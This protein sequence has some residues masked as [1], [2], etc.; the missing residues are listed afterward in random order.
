MN[1][2]NKTIEQLSQRT[3]SNTGKLRTEDERAAFSNN[4]RADIASIL[5]QLNKVYYPLVKTLMSEQALNA[6]DYGLS[7][8]VI[9]T[10]ITANAASAKAYW[11][12]RLVRARTIKETIDVILAEIS[13][14]E[15]LVNILSKGS[16]FDDSEIWNELNE[17]DLNLKQLALDTMGPDYVFGGD[18]LSNLNYSLSQSIDALGAFFNGWP[19]TGNTYT[20]T[21]PSIALSILLSQITLDI[22]LPQNV[23]TNL[24]TDLTAIRNFTGMDN[25]TATPNYS[26]HGSIDYVTDG[27]SLEESIQ[28]LDQVI[29][30]L[31]LP[32]LDNKAV[33]FGDGTDTPATDPNYFVYDEGTSRLGLGTSTPEKTLDVR[34]IIQHDNGV[35]SRGGN[36]RGTAAIDL[37][38][39][40]SVATQ[41][42]S[43]TRAVVLGGQNNSSTAPDA[44]S[45]G[46]ACIAQGQTSVALGKDNLA[47][48]AQATAFGSNNTANGSVAFAKGY[49]NQANGEWSETSGS[50]AV[51]NFRGQK[52]HAAGAFSVP[53]DAQVSDFVV[54]GQTS[55]VGPHELFLDGSGASLRILLADNTSYAVRA[56]I[57][58]RVGNTNTNHYVLEA[59]FKR[60]AGA[61]STTLVGAVTKRVIAEEDVACDATLAADTVNGSLYVQVTGLVGENIR[62]VAHVKTTSV[63][64]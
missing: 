40:R 62:W 55:T 19:G 38:T 61:A 54:R 6:L 8:N 18:G 2:L 42:A 14:L 13:R 35:V 37:Q 9:K 10:H 50:A 43:G 63:T 46:Q 20:T 12:E 23:I 64:F 5:N 3:S 56:D 17:Q 51:T 41:V 58:A 52:A 26:A 48:G 34:G 7:G 31:T 32:N 22:T 49:N 44:I 59:T 36:P 25:A 16:T 30:S 21:F 60:T 45:G 39:I 11:D 27:D 57:I 15:N 1:Q 33:L 24:T 29:A 53:G 47:G 28:I 4:V